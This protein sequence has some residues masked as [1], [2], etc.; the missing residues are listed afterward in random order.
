MSNNTQYARVKQIARR[1]LVDWY[2]NLSLIKRVGLGKTVQGQR[3]PTPGELRAQKVIQR[4]R[5][6]WV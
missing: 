4:R 2:A 1:G 6:N 5:N 3:H